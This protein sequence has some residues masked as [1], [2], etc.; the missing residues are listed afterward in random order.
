MST[1]SLFPSFPPHPQRRG[2]RAGKVKEGKKRLEGKG[3]G[4]RKQLGKERK[5]EGDIG[6]SEEEQRWKGRLEQEEEGRR[7][8]GGSWG[9]SN[10]AGVGDK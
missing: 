6:W 10:N 7:N 8:G 1:S 2:R 3:K 4:R 5:G 9:R